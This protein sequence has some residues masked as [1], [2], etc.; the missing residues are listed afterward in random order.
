MF[1]NAKFQELI[2]AERSTGE[3]I[4]VDRFIVM[5]KGL[6]TAAAGS[7]VLF[8]NGNRGMVREVSAD[9][10]M[11]LNM[12]AEDMPLGS[13]VVI[14][15]DILEVGVGDALIG[16][17]VSAFGQPLD[18][19]GPINLTETR[20]VF[21]TAPGVI[22]RQQ[23]N[24]RLPTGTA[25][26]DLLFPVVLGQRI[27]VL[28]DSKVGKSTFLSSLAVNQLGCDRIVI[29][30]LISKRQVDVDNLIMRLEATGAIKHTIVVIA[31]VFDSL[32]QSYL[33]PYTACAMGE[34][35][36]QTGRDA[37]M[38]YDDLSSHAKIYRELSLLSQGNPGRDSYPGDMFYAHSSLLERAGK[39]ASNGKTLSALP[40]VLTPNDDIT[41]YLS[42]SIMS[43][44]DG[45]I[46][47]DLE[48]YRRGIR[49]A[50]NVGLS[51]SRVGGRVE[52]AREKELTG[53]LFKKLADYRQ[54]AE[55][56]HFGSELASESLADLELG[57]NIYDT[58]K[59]PPEEIYTMNEQGLM[60]GTVIKSEGKIKL[61]IDS[62][63][64]QAREL[65]KQ[66]QKEEDIE[67]GIQKLLT[68]NTV[69][70]AKPGVQPTISKPSTPPAAVA[71]PSIPTEAKSTD[72]P[73]APV[74]DDTTKGKK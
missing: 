18:D 32:V 48:T 19:K 9:N 30:V 67:P 20:P 16:R 35:F 23:L 47:F 13:L 71:S 28:G 33:A 53:K 12:D 68:D 39:L 45:Q 49:P 66:V 34:Y 22:E 38:I 64:R 73:T 51:V 58:F 52:N 36:W 3:V 61:N 6:E 2:D 60:L 70:G 59:Q 41:A 14:E 8:E 37:I 5:V 56:S 29:Y 55:F 65:A 21:A 7:L 74:E 72:T 11:V 43:I 42:T 25:M 69:Q 10:V 31:S 57:K 40:V 4:A 24:E 50:V 15:S 1:D 27:A 46:I 26:V 62:M 63:K 54:A 17:A 44:T